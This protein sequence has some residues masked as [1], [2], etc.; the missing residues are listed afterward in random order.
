MSG[1]A[2]VCS[3]A[4]GVSFDPHGSP[5][6][7]YNSDCG[8]STI[9]ED[10]ACVEFASSKSLNSPVIDGSPPLAST[11]ILPSIPPIASDLQLHNFPMLDG[12]PERNPTYSS[13][14]E[15]DFPAFPRS[16]DS[17]EPFHETSSSSGS[18]LDLC[19][20]T[21]EEAHHQ[22]LLQENPAPRRP[23]V[24]IVVRNNVLEAHGERAT[25]RESFTYT[26]ESLPYDAGL[27]P[28]TYVDNHQRTI[29][30][31]HHLQAL[32]EDLCATDEFVAEDPVVGRSKRSTILRRLAE[33]KMVSKLIA[34][35]PLKST[36]PQNRFSVDSKPPAVFSLTAGF[37]GRNPGTATHPNH[38]DY[39]PSLTPFSPP[40]TYTTSNKK[41]HHTTFQKSWSGPRSLSIFAVPKTEIKGKPASPP[42][43][44]V[45][46]PPPPPQRN[47]AQS[48][49]TDAHGRS[50]GPS[51]IMS[52]E[53]SSDL[54]NV[55]R[56]K[57]RM[58]WLVNARSSKNSRFVG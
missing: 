46:P 30:G 34:F 38:S 50:C 54:S 55:T 53:F 7:K 5:L 52:L 17:V 21:A 56:R 6:S 29:Q 13:A 26:C 41:R 23:T 32:E 2:S 43:P 57:E 58:S 37:A 47:D 40:P 25:R 8:F 10:P 27:Q 22:I 15:G 3:C 16:D 4:T 39:S 44:N 36:N 12:Q 14:T 49:Q 28:H 35:G 45:E 42:L 18:A 9:Q 24:R 48:H 20:P 19:I 33:G 31:K 51:R 1:N 11:N